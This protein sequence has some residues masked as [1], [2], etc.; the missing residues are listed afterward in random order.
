[1]K[2][3][4]INLSSTNLFSINTFPLSKMQYITIRCLFFQKKKGKKSPELGVLLSSG[5]DVSYTAQDN[6]QDAL[7]FQD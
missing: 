7:R 6:R 3:F 2:L 5:P 1:M 4:T